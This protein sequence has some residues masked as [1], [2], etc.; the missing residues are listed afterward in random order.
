M[1]WTFVRYLVNYFI[2]YITQDISGISSVSMFDCINS[3]EH[4]P[5]VLVQ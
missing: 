2:K 5:E 3:F 1:R 4:V